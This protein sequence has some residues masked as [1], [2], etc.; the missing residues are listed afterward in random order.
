MSVLKKKKHTNL[1]YN[2]HILLFTAT[3]VFLLLLLYIQIDTLIQTAETEKKHFAQSV[4]LS[5]NLAAEQIS[6][7]RQMCSNVKS[8][9]QKKEG[10]VIKELR[11]REW[12]K[13]DS[14]IKH[15][16]ELYD[17][18][19]A[20]EFEITNKKND[21][22]TG[23]FDLTS[24]ICFAE[25]LDIDL[26]QA[27]VDLHVKFPEKNE[28][29]V[30]RIS[31]MFV[32][33]ILLIFLLTIAFITALKLYIKEK[34]IAEKTRDFVNNMTHEFKTPI[35]NIGFANHRIQN[36][37]D[38]VL[39]EKI[40]NYTD[41]IE[42]E[43]NKLQNQIDEILN[44][45]Y[46]EDNQNGNGFE[47]LDIG[48]IVSEA[49]KSIELAVAEKGGTINYEDKAELLIVEGN[50]LHLLNSVTNILDNAYKYSNKNL[51]ID[52]K[53][54]NTGQNIVIEIADNGIGISSKDQKYIF[55]KYYR[56]PTGNIHNIK[57][58]GI[59]LTYVKEVVGQ[60]SGKIEFKSTEG[61]GC[62]FKIILPFTDHK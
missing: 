23:G 26:Q 52:I 20:Y 17:I 57:G 16:L 32:S 19:L 40:V 50:R 28:F 44:V 30:K 7:D 45:A 2:K 29:I 8:C 12:A 62:N 60:H 34:N 38:I 1:K 27:G 5:L 47:T 53:T 31:T 59:G 11:K 13:V 37:K 54:Y 3:F 24:E 35:A 4:R 10:V 36:N 58:Y 41:I 9:L 55:D 6:K 48:N 56:V 18:D 25:S 21:K 22:N 39:P 42:K 49:I 43:K 46:L 51:R 61:K 14:I 15:N 33:S